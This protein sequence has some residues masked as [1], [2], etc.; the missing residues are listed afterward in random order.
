MGLS[1]RCETESQKH[2]ANPAW[3]CARDILTG[4]HRPWDSPPLD[5]AADDPSR[6][7]RVIAIVRPREGKHAVNQ[8]TGR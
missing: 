5:E 4:D 3:W 7:L 2:S 1:I 6:R 8:A